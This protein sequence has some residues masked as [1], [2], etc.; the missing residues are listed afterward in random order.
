MT[1]AQ[2]M[3]QMLQ[4]NGMWPA[5]ATTIIEQA[6]TNAGLFDPSLRWNDDI[7]GYPAPL[8]AAVWGS[9]KFVAVKWIDVNKPRHFARMILSSGE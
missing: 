8:L 2:K 7:E 5:E 9:V 6:K 1:V 3:E 4:E